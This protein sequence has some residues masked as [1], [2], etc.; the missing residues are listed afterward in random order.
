[1]PAVAGAPGV[2]VGALAHHCSGLMRDLLDTEGLPADLGRGCRAARHWGGCSTRCWRSPAAR[3]LWLHSSSKR[4]SSPSRTSGPSSAPESRHRARRAGTACLGSGS[5]SAR[6]DEPILENTI[7][8]ADRTV[9]LQLRNPAGVWVPLQVALGTIVDDHDGRT[10]LHFQG[11]PGDYIGLG[12]AP[13]APGLA[14]AQDS[15]PGRRLVIDGVSASNAGSP[16][17]RQVRSSLAAW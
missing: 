5:A 9:G 11:Q 14:R 7:P 3:N 8:Q 17:T 10:F 2:R 6:V 4:A 1:M 13:C 12:S 16:A 15:A